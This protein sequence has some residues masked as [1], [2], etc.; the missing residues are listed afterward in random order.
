MIAGI[1][2]TSL[3]D[4]PGKVAAVLYTSPCNFRCPFCHNRQLALGEGTRPMPEEEVTEML[5]ARRGFVDGVVIT[6]GEPTVSTDIYKWIAVLRALKYAVKLD[7]N[8]YDPGVL[9]MLLAVGGIDFVAMDVKTSWPKYGRAAGIDV[10]TNRI[11]ESIELI[12]G[13]GVK[14]EFRT[15]CVPSLVDGEDIEEISRLVGKSG[16]YTLQQFQPGNNL[17]PDFRN[18]TP[19]PVEVLREFLESARRNTASCRLIGVESR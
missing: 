16:Q 6:G 3:I 18:V 8:G 12:K 13:S 19:Y 1:K 10:N 11:M 7:T 5:L 14:H 9:R 4:Y 2:G 17:E 15:T